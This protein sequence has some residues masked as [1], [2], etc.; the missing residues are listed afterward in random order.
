MSAP[1]SHQPSDKLL[2]DYQ[3]ACSEVIVLRKGL[4]EILQSV[5]QHDGEL[6]KL[7]MLSFKKKPNNIELIGTSDVKIESPILERLVTVLNSERLFGHYDAYA[8]IMNENSRLYG[9]NK[10]MRERVREIKTATF[11]TVEHPP[12]VCSPP[13]PS[14][15][16]SSSSDQTLKMDKNIQVSVQLANSG[17]DPHIEEETR[18]PVEI[19][20]PSTPPKKEPEMVAPPQ[21]VAAESQCELTGQMEQYQVK[22]CDLE[23]Q[24][25]KV[26]HELH[27]LTEKH[28]AAVVDWQRREANWIEQVASN[29]TKMEELQQDLRSKEKMLND[30]QAAKASASVEQTTSEPTD[31]IKI[32]SLL[33]P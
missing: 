24:L 19:H 14:S 18:P 22:L 8:D 28:D 32:V 4:I 11:I 5:R 9:E 17:C 26:K 30:L 2:Q 31:E 16:L 23:L 7:K 6:N 15:R 20:R 13:V 29:G 33:D 1:V 21:R 12:T 25:G 10:L 27:N 3:K